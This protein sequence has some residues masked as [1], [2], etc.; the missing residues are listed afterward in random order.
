MQKCEEKCAVV[1]CDWQGSDCSSHSKLLKVGDAGEDGITQN[2]MFSRVG[3]V[4]G[5]NMG[6]LV[7][8]VRCLWRLAEYAT[9]VERE[10]EDESRTCVYLERIR[11]K[12]LL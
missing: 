11:M 2:P 4:P 1:Y 6:N 10:M 9:I 8:R 3:C 7:Q 5:G 12:C